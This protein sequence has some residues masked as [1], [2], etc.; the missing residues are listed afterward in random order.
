MICGA[1]SGGCSWRTMSCDTLDLFECMGKWGRLTCVT[2]I[3]YTLV[4][5]FFRVYRTRIGK[6]IASIWKERAPY[7][8]DGQKLVSF[9]LS[10]WMLDTRPRKVAEATLFHSWWSRLR[11]RRKSSGCMEEA[12]VGIKTSPTDETFRI[13]RLDE[14]L[15]RPWSGKA[16][17]PHGNVL[18]D[19]ARYKHVKARTSRMIGYPAGL[20]LWSTYAGCCLFIDGRLLRLYGSLELFGREPYLSYAFLPYLVSFKL[21]NKLFIVSI[22]AVIYERISLEW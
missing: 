8:T 17:I 3:T 1:N 20:P 6:R 21:E 22:C 19:G 18:T 15:G 13:Y 7:N 5:D 2:Y 14:K 16:A 10:I 9:Q 4:F 11:V 12:Q